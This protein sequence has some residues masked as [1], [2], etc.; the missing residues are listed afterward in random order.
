M[1]TAI[2][3]ILPALAILAIV[4]AAESANA[5]APSQ[6]APSQPAEAKT[7]PDMPPAK[8]VWVSIGILGS[9]NDGEGSEYLG[10]IPAKVF[11]G[12]LDGTHRGLVPVESCCYLDEQGELN[13]LDELD[14]AYTSTAYFPVQRVERIIPLRQ[15]TIDRI[16]NRKL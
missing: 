14:A 1:I 10:R 15:P 7:P 13:F 4:W 9:S 12:L 8:P 5:Q 16:T 2:R 11:A 6:P 3:M